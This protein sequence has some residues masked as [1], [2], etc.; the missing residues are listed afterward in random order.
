M[1]PEQLTQ[2]GLRVK[3]IDWNGSYVV[4]R[5]FGVWR[6]WYFSDPLRGPD[7]KPIEFDSAG[8]ARAAAEA[9]HA[10]RIAAQIEVIE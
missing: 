8:D 2:R 4:A 7:G 5:S 3:P 10:A 6:A 1:T 9:D